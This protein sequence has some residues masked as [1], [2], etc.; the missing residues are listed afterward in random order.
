MEE[1]DPVLGNREISDYE[2]FCLWNMD[3]YCGGLSIEIGPDF[4]VPFPSQDT[5]LQMQTEATAMIAMMRQSLEEMDFQRYREWGKLLISRDLWDQLLFLAFM[6]REWQM[7]GRIAHIYVK[8]VTKRE[9]TN[10]ISAGVYLAFES[11]CSDGSD[12]E[13]RHCYTR[14]TRS[15]S[16]SDELTYMHC[17]WGESDE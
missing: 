7:H 9:S 11:H 13:Y 14:L 15:N 6:V 16:K 10:E 17:Q 12:K 5:F 2:R 8:R 1:T 4:Y 3:N